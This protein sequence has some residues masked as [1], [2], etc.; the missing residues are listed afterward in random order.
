MKKI[1]QIAGS[2]LLA[3]AISLSV[4]ACAEDQ[5]PANIEYWTVSSNEKIMLDKEYD[6]SEKTEKTL[7][8]RGSR[9]EYES[10]QIIVTPDKAVHGVDL[11]VT[12]LKNGDSV[13][14][15]E[16]IE[17]YYEKYYYLDAM[18]NPEYRGEYGS[19]PDALVPLDAIQEKGEDSIAGNNNQGLWVTVEVPADDELAAGTY[20]GTFTL[21]VE[22][23][24]FSVPV[25]FVLWD[26]SMPEEAHMQTIF[27]NFREHLMN[28]ELDNS[29][30][31][32]E[33]YTDWLLDYRISVDKLPVFTKDAAAV[34]EK[35]KKYSADPRCASYGLNVYFYIANVE[36]LDGTV[37]SI[38]ETDWDLL[39]EYVLALA[40]A[41]TPELN[42]LEKCNI[43][44]QSIDEPEG[45]NRV[46]E[47]NYKQTR[48]DALKASCVAQLKE[49]QFDF[50]AHGITEG[51]ILGIEYVVTNRYAA[52]LANMSTYCPLINDL[53]TA[54]QRALYESLEERNEYNST[55]WYVAWQP[56]Y[57]YPNF[58][59][60]ESSVG[61]RTLAWMQMDYD[62]EG[63]LYWGT[64]VYAGIDSNTGFG[65]IRDPYT[66]PYPFGGALATNDGMLTYPGRPYGIYGPLPSIRLMSWRDGAEDYEY[67]WYL[68]ELL[69]DANETYETDFDFN[70]MMRSIYDSMYSGTIPNYSA[71]ALDAARE[72]VAGLIEL[73]ES[74]ANAVITIDRI[75]AA[76]NTATY[77]I[78]ASGD[79]AVEVKNATLQETKDSGS[80][81]LYTYSQV[82]SAATNYIEATFTTG[83]VVTQVSRY[84]GKR[85]NAVSLFE[86]SEPVFSVSNGFVLHPQDHITVA[87][88]NDSVEGLSENTAK[89]TVSEYTAGTATEIA[90]YTPYIEIPASAFGNING[91]QMDAFGFSIYSPENAGK[92]VRLMLVAN[93]TTERVGSVT[94]GTGILNVQFDQIY[95]TSWDKLGSVTAVRIVFEK[96][97]A[98]ADTY[99]VDNLF[100]TTRD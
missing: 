50:A 47:A 81:K 55:W 31:M 41:S 9:G 86:G 58:R 33:Y 84:L 57:P 95:L 44:D 40:E 36:M 49:Q 82:M 92:Q 71:D 77:S 38:N 32:V 3:G 29:E 60:E 51:D 37:K 7:S 25:Q 43:Y 21:K 48:I 66:D 88:G 74:E 14:P 23:Q 20:T 67:L 91:T 96:A 70:G 28:G 83:S 72:E 13:I 53:N 64:S 12:D 73:L 46:P 93:G 19:Y 45:T 8:M 34:V 2:L 99:Y 39:E 62:I 87:K 63:F 1:W 26:F 35:A 59:V 6:A 54:E 94:L 80:G 90:A 76:T 42:L 65:N 27:N 17:V 79:T 5:T 75:D 16:N 11:T 89:I 78:Y 100:Y 15:A 69:T 24:S 56:R 97:D 10:A 98:T 30:E 61:M 85:T 18:S 68:R 52:N 22:E 4:V